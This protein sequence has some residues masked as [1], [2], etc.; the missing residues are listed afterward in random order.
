M[1][2]PDHHSCH[3]ILPCPRHALCTF[4]HSLYDRRLDR[5]TAALSELTDSRVDVVRD[6]LKN[7]SKVAAKLY[8]RIIVNPRG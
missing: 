6:R 8:S 4:R 3:G 1:A 2:S 7:V 5:M